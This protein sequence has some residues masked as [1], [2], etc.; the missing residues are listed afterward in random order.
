MGAFAFL[1][2]AASLLV[3][4]QVDRLTLGRR[5]RQGNA[6]LLNRGDPRSRLVKFILGGLLIPIAAFLAANRVELADHETPMSMAIRASRPVL[7]VSDA[8]RLGA[9]VLRAASPAAKVQGIQALQS[10]GSSETFDQLLR[11]AHEDPVALR[12]G[13]VYRALSRALASF[14]GLAR[15]RLLQDLDATSTSVRREATAPAGD[16]YRRY[17][18]AAFE[19]ARDEAT[20]RPSD[21][22][23]QAAELSC[24][25]AARADLLRDLGPVGAEVRPGQASR[26]LPAFILE[27]FLAMDL[28]QDEELLSLAKRTAADS[29]WSDAVRGEALLLVAKLG[30]RD[31]LPGLYAYLDSPSALLQARAMEAIAGLQARLAPAAPSR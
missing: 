17:F 20:A 9:A 30:N 23:A 18:S 21:P 26:A 10:V 4:I 14:G 1:L 29:G 12:D 27:T 31:D 22:A 25:E 16:L 3:S 19:A 13:G 8:Q 24:L 5:L 15:V 7:V 28:R 11:I 6:R 2:V